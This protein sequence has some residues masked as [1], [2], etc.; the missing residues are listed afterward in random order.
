MFRHQGNS[1]TIHH[2]LRIAVVLSFVAG[3][4]NVAGFLAFRQLTTNVTGHFTFF[5]ADLAEGLFWPS[6]V[7]FLYIFSFLIG[8]LAASLLIEQFKS[9]KKLNIFV[10]PTFIEIILLVL[11]GFLNYSWAISHANLLICILLFTMGLQNSFVTKIS[12]AVVRTTHLTGLFTDLGIDLS[13]LFFPKRHPD[14]GKLKANIKLRIFI[15]CSFLGGG[16][17]AGF[18]YS[19]WNLGLRTLLVAAVILLASLFLDDFRFRWIRLKRRHF[20]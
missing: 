12:N 9:T 6:L 14:L 7:Y 4:V 16:L 20:R 2:N 13:Y 5:V 17:L 1:R 19:E 10:V 11:V 15:I 3:K 8:S 18:L